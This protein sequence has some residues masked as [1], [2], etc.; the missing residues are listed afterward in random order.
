M[1]ILILFWAKGPPLVLWNYL[2]TIHARGATTRVAE[3]SGHCALEFSGGTYQLDFYTES[4]LRDI[5]R[6]S[7]ELLGIHTPEDVLER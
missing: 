1:V 4:D 7:S 6:R 2:S 3:L 5:I